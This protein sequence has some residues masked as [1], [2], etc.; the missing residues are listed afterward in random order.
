MS[1][2]TQKGSSTEES[3]FTRGQ[4]YRSLRSIAEFQEKK[5]KSKVSN[6]LVTC[7]LHATL[8]LM[9]VIFQFVAVMFHFM[10]VIF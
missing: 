10:T 5:N 4:A 9:S 8:W 6:D 1:H 7:V 2:N 3:R